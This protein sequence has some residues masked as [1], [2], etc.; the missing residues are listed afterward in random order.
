MFTKIRYTAAISGNY[1]AVLENCG[2]KGKQCHSLPCIKQQQ[3]N[4]NFSL[5]QR[6][7]SD[8]FR[9]CPGCDEGSFK[10]HVANCCAIVTVLS[11]SLHYCT[12]DFK[13]NNV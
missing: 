5:F 4:P 11:T 8:F 6:F 3:R 2:Y 10:I 7:D 9:N 12:T 1:R 13:I